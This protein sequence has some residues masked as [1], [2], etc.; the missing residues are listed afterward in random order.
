M[1]ALMQETKHPAP[2]SIGGKTSGSATDLPW[3]LDPLKQVPHWVVWSFEK[4]NGKQ[5]KV[6]YQLNG[7]LAS[8]KDPATWSTFEEVRKLAH[9]FDGV[10]F[11]LQESTIAAFDIDN[12]R[13]PDSGKVH[14]WAQALVEKAGSYAEVTPSGCGLRILG[15]GA[16]PAAHRKLKVTDKVSCELYRRATRYITVTGWV[17]NRA[18]L[19]DIDAVIDATYDELSK[20][21][22]KVN[23]TTAVTPAAGSA[24]GKRTDLPKSTSLKLHVQGSGTYPSR[25]E[26]LFAF[27]AEAL[28]AKVSDLTIIAECLQSRPGC[29]IYEHVKTGGSKY[30]ER[31][32][33]RAREKIPD[34]R[35]APAFSDEALALKFAERHA[36]D[37]RRVAAWGKWFRW[38]G[39]RWQD[40]QTLQGFDYA[41]AICREEAARCN[42]EG[43]AKGLAS[44][45]TVAAVERLA[46][47]DR[48]LA[49]TIDQWDANPWLLNTPAGVVDLRTGHI[50]PPFPQNY[51][52]KL[53]AVSPGGAC[54][55]WHEFLARVTDG[56]EELQKFL[57]R[58][59]GYGLTGSIAEH[60][61]FF[62]WGTGANG[63]GRFVEAITGC[64]GDYHRTAPIE[65]FIASQGERHPTEIA[66]LRGARIVTATETEE[67]RRWAESKL[68]ALTGGDRITARFMRQ[69]FFDFTPRFKL[70]V[71]GNHKPGLRSVD[72]A[73]R[74]RIHL[75]P[76]TVT[77]P[78]AER[79]TK[80]GEKLKAEWPGILAWMIEGCIAWQEIGLAPPKA[81]SDATDDYLTAEDTIGTWLTERCIK[82][83]GAWTST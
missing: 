28:R 82:N 34:G 69:D 75:V 56:D 78:E 18:P 38:T 21:T 11:C 10:G 79:D 62:L 17:H 48:R 22:A 46:R 64:L 3:E 47:T 73:I 54:P 39:Q 77:I 51:Q 72:E 58:M 53:T 4:R 41:R 27:I 61:F 35:V 59:S 40:E 67:S 36:D 30:V 37:L 57:Q 8:S 31:Q 15:Y 74:R 12:C 23:G 20:S 81:V 68:K 71:S 1:A 50:S 5:T 44:G 76:F 24:A 33:E 26:L 25:S 66:G 2:G 52:T 32:I 14:P 70:I 63:K 13:D 55:R 60:A 29:G 45:K 80:L 83:G 7:S 65:A 6:P 16:G 9:K 42:K 49:A 19:A 43:M